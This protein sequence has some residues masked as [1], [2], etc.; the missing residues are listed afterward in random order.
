MKKLYY[1]QW[2]LFL[3][4]WEQAQYGGKANVIKR[5]LYKKFKGYDPYDN[6]NPKNPLYYCTLNSFYYENL[7]RLMKESE[8]IK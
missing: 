7:E 5:W 3:F 6:E 1:C 2:P 8:R 4:P